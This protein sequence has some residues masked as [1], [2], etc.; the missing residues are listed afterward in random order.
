MDYRLRKV[1]GLD[2]DSDHSSL[3]GQHDSDSDSGRFE[4]TKKRRRA[5]VPQHSSD[6]LEGGQHRQHISKEVGGKASLEANQKNV[7]GECSFN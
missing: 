3:S 5:L 7:S 6:S 1:D 2:S 4:A